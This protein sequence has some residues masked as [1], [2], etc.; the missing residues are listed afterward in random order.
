M[1]DRNGNE[2]FWFFYNK[3]LSK[4]PISNPWNRNLGKLIMPKAFVD[5]DLLKKL[6][7]S[8]NAVTRTFHKHNGSILCT[9]DMTSL[10]E[11]FGLEG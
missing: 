10:I 11:A 9:L 3:R 7:N 2:L 6:I 4:A 1:L 8:Y 5:V